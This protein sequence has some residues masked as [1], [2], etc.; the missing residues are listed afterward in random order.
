MANNITFEDVR[1]SRS[2]DIASSSGVGGRDSQQDAAYIAAADNDAFAVVCDGMGGIAGGELASTTAVDAFVEFYQYYAE[3]K[4]EAFDCSWLQS[5]AE[6][7]D[8]IVYSL[9]DAAGRRIGAG[10]TLISVVIHKNQLHWL[11]VGDSRIYIARG[12][13]MVQV[14][15][16]HNYFMRLDQQRADGL[17]S[18][19]KY[20]EEARK[21]DAL[22]SFIGMG[23]LLLIDINEEPFELQ[24]GDAVLLCTDGV[25]RTL[26][27]ME[28]QY[29]ITHSVFTK[30]VA[31]CFEKIIARRMSP[32]QDNYTYVIIKKV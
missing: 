19:Q 22:I 18:A 8:D 16:D 5:A 7:I 24:S 15:N 26:S 32:S 30:D 2:Y 11:S 25:Y 20:H 9:K 6:A 23:G 14:T 27:E 12:N 31:D 13:E 3:K 10:T 21:G 4:G 29:I 17:L 28:M 1:T